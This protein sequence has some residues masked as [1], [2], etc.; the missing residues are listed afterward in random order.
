MTRGASSVVPSERASQHLALNGWAVVDGGYER[1][2]LSL[3]QRRLDALHL[4]FGAP[5]FYSERPRWV[6]P[7]VEVARPGLAFYRLLGFAPEL[8]PRLFRA[9]VV[10][11]MRSILGADLHL[12]LVGAVLSDE[13]RPFTEW[14]TH[15]GGIDDERWRGEGR[16]PRRARTRRIAH[17][18]FLEPLSEDTGPWRVLPRRRGDSPEPPASIDDEDW[19]G[20]QTLTFPAGSVLLLDESTWH[21]VRPRRTPGTRRFVGAYLASADAE[22][23]FGVDET[24]LALDTGDPLFDSL[25]RRAPQPLG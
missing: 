9:P 21:S 20:A 17:F 6:A 22:A 14:E 10:E 5:P 19:P 2:T 23:T 25:L 16:R 15:L 11:V 4:R 12:E 24:L 3:I 8:A 18:L 1:A 13:T 7:N